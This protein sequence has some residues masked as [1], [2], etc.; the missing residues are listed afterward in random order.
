M[1]NLKIR[2]GFRI[3]LNDC[4]AWNIH[5]VMLVFVKGPVSDNE[6]ILIRA[7]ATFTTIDNS[8]LRN[9]WRRSFWLRPRRNLW[10][11]V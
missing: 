6:F 2:A 5:N 7:A 10:Q 8:G 4:S 3:S 1:I 9:S 11:E